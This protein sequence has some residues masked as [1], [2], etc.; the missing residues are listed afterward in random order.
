MGIAQ[1]LLFI[2]ALAPFGGRAT[3]RLCHLVA[4]LQTPLQLAGLLLLHRRG[5]KA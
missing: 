4:P 1:M 3:T 2:A 5:R